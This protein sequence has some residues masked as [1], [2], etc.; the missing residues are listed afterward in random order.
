MDATT[1]TDRYVDAAMHTVPEKQRADLAAE[2]QASI[3]DQVDARVDSGEDAHAAEVAVLTELGDPDV[4]AAGYTGRVLHLIGPRYYLDWWRLLKLLLWIVPAC[5]AFAIALGQVIQLAPIGSVVG[6]AVVGALGSVVQVCFWTTLVFVVLERLGRETMDAGPWTPD[7][8]PAPRERGAR[9]SDLV[10]SLVWLLL[11]AGAVLWDVFRGLAFANGTWMPVFDP[12]LWPAW[13][14][15]LFAVLAAFAVVSV[16]VYR[17]GGWSYALAAVHGILDVL[18][19]GAI[20]WLLL[21][22]RLLNPALV[23]ALGEATS[24]EVP[25]ILGVL[26]AVGLAIVGVWDALDAFRKARGSNRA[27]TRVPA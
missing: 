4:L 12:A 13:M 27:E 20:I 15:A 18:L 21:E 6:P 7:R 23:S 14:I 24:A 19:F 17:R 9:F 3:A 16:L 25:R 2:L 22:G 1:L 10:T 8:L 5:T 26:L 11:V